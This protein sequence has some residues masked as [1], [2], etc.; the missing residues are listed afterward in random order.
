MTHQDEE[1]QKKFKCDHCS[2]AF[3]SMVELKTHLKG[4][5]EKKQRKFECSEKDCNSIFF[6][7]SYLN[8]HVKEVHEKIKKFECESCHKMF[9]RNWVLK[10]H[11]Q[12]NHEETKMETCTLCNASV[13]NLLSHL[14]QWW[15]N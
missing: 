1:A 14:E 5:H 9:S 12:K 4:V 7:K 3:K 6:K 13:K 15:D 2:K 8:Q 11:I 10:V